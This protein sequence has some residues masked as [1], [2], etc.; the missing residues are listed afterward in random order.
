VSAPNEA[1]AKYLVVGGFAII[2]HGFARATEHIDLLKKSKLM[3][4]AAHSPA[5]S[6][7]N[8]NS[9]N[10][11]ASFACLAGKI[12][13]PAEVTDA[14]FDSEIEVDARHLF[15]EGAHVELA[16]NLPN[17]GQLL[18]RETRAA[19]GQRRAFHSVFNQSKYAATSGSHAKAPS[20]MIPAPTK[21]A[22]ASSMYFPTP[23]SF[24]G[25][26]GK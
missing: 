26:A 16:F 22:L 12:P 5:R 10:L 21:A 7:F 9:F 4:F 6:T 23:Y 18:L 17:A 20:G 13:H 3:E 11:L 24:N 14:L 8:G 15:A 1:G 25:L 2:Q 19:V